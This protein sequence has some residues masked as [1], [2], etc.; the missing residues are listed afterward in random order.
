MSQGGFNKIDASDAKMYGSRGI[1]LCGYDISEQE[2]FAELLIENGVDNIHLVSANET[3]VEQTL[4]E[5]V[6]S[7]DRTGF[8]T[9]STLPRASILSG[10]TE[11]E[12]HLIISMVRGSEMPGQLWASM[13][14]TSETWKLKDLLAELIRER[15]EFRKRKA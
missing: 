6:A 8:G 12:L 14:P 5:I 3:H 15:E 2:K 11:K 13:T 1:I 10:I 7:P 9:K 4:G